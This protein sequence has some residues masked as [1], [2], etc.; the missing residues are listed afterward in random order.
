MSSRDLT[1][2]AMPIPS[3]ARAIMVPIA[4]ATMSGFETED[5]LAVD[6]GA[7]PLAKKKYK[8][9]LQH[10]TIKEDGQMKDNTYSVFSLEES[11]GR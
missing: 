2:A 11:F 3:A 5:L 8:D 9:R 10:V 4:T 6:V 7:G 1:S